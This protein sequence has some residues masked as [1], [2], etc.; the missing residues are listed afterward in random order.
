[1]SG[2]QNA[3]NIII[4]I[5]QDMR[6]VFRLIDIALLTGE[7]AFQPLNKKLNYY[8]KTGKLNNSRKGIYTKTNYNPQELACKIFIPSYISRVCLAKSRHYFSIRFR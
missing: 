1:M 7:T 6:T 5:Y 2:S 8:V 4:A 3:G